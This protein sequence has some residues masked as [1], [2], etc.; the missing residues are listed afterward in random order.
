MASIYPRVRE[1]LKFINQAKEAVGF[2]KEGFINFARIEQS[3]MNEKEL[4]DLGNQLVKMSAETIRLAL[5]VGM[6]TPTRN[7]LSKAIID[8][9]VQL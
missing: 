7:I 8:K 4:I 1:Y 5:G 6:K 3:K 9:G 2:A